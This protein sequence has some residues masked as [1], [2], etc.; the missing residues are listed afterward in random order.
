MNQLEKIHENRTIG[1]LARN[2]LRSP[3]QSNGLH[4]TDAELIALEGD[5][6]RLLAITIDTIADEIAEGLYRDPF[7]MGW[8]TVMASFSDLA[9]VGAEP[10]GIVTAVSLERSRNASFRRRIA[11][12]M[13]QACRRVGSFILGGDLN[14]THSISLTGCA[15]GQVSRNRKIARIGCH[16][17]DVVFLSGR[18]GSGNALGL[19]RKTRLPDEVYPEKK[20]RPVARTREALLVRQYASCCMDTSDGLFITIDQLIR[21]NGRGFSIRTDWEDILEKDACRLCEG[22][23]VPFWFMAA[24]IHGEFELLFTV[25][26]SKTQAFLREAA[27]MDFHPI[28]LG[29]ITQDPHFELSLESGKKTAIDMTHLRN[30]WDKTS[31]DIGQILEEH[32]SSGKSWGLH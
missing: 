18:A 11:E 30:L 23:N 5:E 17:G 27:R 4:E 14:F 9:A 25:P 1:N 24:G 13:E 10:I 7:T 3:H 19:A 12:G 8:V 15:I 6:S 26:E 22:M 20:Y 16:A 31:G 29:I 28:S 2:F 32:F 21:L